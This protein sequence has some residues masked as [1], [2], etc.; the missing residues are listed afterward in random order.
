M[1]PKRFKKCFLW[2]LVFSNFFEIFRFF[3]Q[4]DVFRLFAH[5][6]SFLIEKSFK[7]PRNMA[8]FVPNFV[9]NF[10][11]SRSVFIRYNLRTNEPKLPKN[12]SKWACSGLK[13]LE[14]WT[15]FGKLPR[16]KFRPFSQII[17]FQ[18]AFRFDLISYGVFKKVPLLRPSILTFDIK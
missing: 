2:F 8:Y 1:V 11:R 13:F 4:N 18:N 17:R 7:S 5:D 12:R 9:L 14:T 16:S 3:S 10:P 6:Y 15:E